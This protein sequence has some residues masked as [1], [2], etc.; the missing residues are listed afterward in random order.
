LCHRQNKNG[1][2]HKPEEPLRKI[3]VS[4]VILPSLI[5]LGVVAY[6][7]F[8]NF[9][10]AAFHA[11]EFTKAS[12]FWL[13]VAGLMM[14]IR[15]FGYVI[16]IKILT[17]NQLSWIQAIRVILLW[18]FTS[19][20][21]PSAIGG[22]SVAILYVNKEGIGIGKSSAV[23]MAT[24][25]LDELYFIIMFPLLLLLINAQELFSIG[26][27]FT[28]SNPYLVAAVTGYSLKLLWVLAI[29]Y[30]LFK[31]P[32]GFKWLLLLVFKLPFLRR[33]RPGANNAGNEI[34][35]SS[36]EL[37]KQKFTF[38]LKAFGATFFSWTARYWVVNAMFL[39]FF[40]VHDHFLLFVRQLVMWIMML[41]TPTPGGSGL[42][43]YVF[44]EYL[45]DFLPFAGVAVL[46]A[47][48]WR[49]FT[50]YPYLIIG[51]FL[52]PRWL[53]MKFGKKNN[54]L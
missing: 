1:M 32:R 7:L 35:E 11:V 20:I 9:N 17:S 46:M 19:A 49:L 8:K 18:E 10:I 30:G 37:K 52:F 48:L 12:V 5:G 34:I 39:A 51:A 24:S 54:K 40:V 26:G 15:D 42:S 16:R 27:G 6:M 25:F 33:W 23:V 22:T 21:T 41:V 53:K 38:W 29:S 28:L 47:L 4:R 2:S 45:G 43:E 36:K 31:N 50:Y 3:K 44:T 13:L 14:F